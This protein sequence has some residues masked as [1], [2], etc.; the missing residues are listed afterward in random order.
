MEEKSYIISFR[1]PFVFEGEKYTQIDLSGLEELTG[2]DIKELQ[3]VFFKP[4]PDNMLPEF[5]LDYCTAVAER[6]AG[7]PLEFFD[8][9][10]AYILSQI[11]LMVQGFFLS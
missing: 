8:Q 5:D 6:V 4:S 3:K 7:L 9:A 11:K 1:K 2:K 10:P